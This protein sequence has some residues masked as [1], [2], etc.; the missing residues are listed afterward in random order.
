M[1]TR[2]FRCIIFTFLFLFLPS[3]LFTRFSLYI[4]FDLSLSEGKEEKG[5]LFLRLLFTLPSP[6][7]AIYAL[8]VVVLVLVSL[9]CCFK[10]DQHKEKRRRSVLV[11][12]VLAF[13]FQ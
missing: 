10:E 5:P 12:V 4:R 3:F 8:L 9:G 1:L 6:L 13:D 2:F 7:K 11:S